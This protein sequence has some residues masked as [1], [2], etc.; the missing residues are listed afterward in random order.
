M[1]METN[2]R[3]NL[4]KEDIVKNI[5]LKFGIS[6][7]YSSTILNNLIDILILNISV[8][9]KIKIKNFGNFT[10]Q[11]KKKRPGR[12]PKSKRKYDISARKV[13]TFKAANELK[14]KINNNAKK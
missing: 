3:D 8:S 7:S 10:L 9:E 4:T 13:V 11:T 6:T 5:T 14:L 2:K 1:T 12:D